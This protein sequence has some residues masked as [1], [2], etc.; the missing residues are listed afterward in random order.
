MSQKNFAAMT[1]STGAASP[2]TKELI[3][4][5]A[6]KL[7]N[8]PKYGSIMLNKALYLIDS[9]SYL[10]T[11]HPISEFKYIKQGQ[12][13]TPAPSQFLPL[14]D[15]LVASNDL[16]KVNA[17]YFGRTQYKFIAK[18]EPKID[19][20]SPEEIFVIDEV[21]EKICDLSAAELSEYTHQLIAWIVAKEKEELPLHSYLLTKE[22]PEMK[23]IEWAKK[24]I[25]KYQSSLKDTH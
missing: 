14:R 8:K 10:K 12:G 7:G 19:V 11:G 9:T 15:S 23:D 16:E 21:L 4:Y 24:S 3:I 18:R 5:I 6:S 13:P 1:T 2:K 22:E 25:K 20:F 17:D